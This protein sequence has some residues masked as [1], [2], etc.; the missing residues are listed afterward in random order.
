MAVLRLKL[1]SMVAPTPV[2]AYLHSAAMVAAGVF[3]V[4]RTY[5]LLS[6]SEL[7]LDALVIIGFASIAVGSVLALTRDMLK[8]VLAYSTI[9]QYGYVL[10]MLG[11]GG[12]SGPAGSAFYV[13]A[14]AL[15]KSALFMT[16]GAVSQVTGEDRLSRLGG[17]ASSLPLIAVVSGIAAAGLAGLP[18]TIGF[19]KDELLFKVALERG[20]SFAALAA[21]G[22]ALT[23]AY[24]WRF[25]SGIFLG[26]EKRRAGRA[27]VRLV[28]PIAALGLL[29]FAG[30]LVAGPFA[31]LSEAAGAVISGASASIRPA[32]QLD[33]RPENLLAVSSYAL[34]LLILIAAPL[35]REA[36]QKLAASGERFGPERWCAAGLAGLRRLSERLHTISDS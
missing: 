12:G 17:L 29:A 1:K 34:A 27:P 33:L 30:G 26:A 5:P 36:A 7:L 31:R 35:W 2:S 11:L 25:W 14:H 16:A 28:M 10:L 3:L 13:I 9:A 23:F 18:L 24:S 19:F 6:R 4:Q 21:V 20:W 8:Q 15:V 22:V 32:Y